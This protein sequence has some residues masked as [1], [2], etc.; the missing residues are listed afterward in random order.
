M[1][2]ARRAR[3]GCCHCFFLFFV[4][5]FRVISDFIE[6]FWARI[7]RRACAVARVPDGYWPRSATIKY[8]Y[9]TSGDQ[10][11]RKTIRK[12]STNTV[13]VHTEFN[14]VEILL[15]SR[16]SCSPSS[17]PPPKGN[18]GTRRYKPSEINIGITIVHRRVLFSKSIFNTVHSSDHRAYIFDRIVSQSE[19]FDFK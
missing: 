8:I 2:V 14:A 15:R 5:A 3:D 6:T 12:T 13:Q 17:S 4:N 7:G 9:I 19:Q 10:T 11:K 1:R 18:W 16:R